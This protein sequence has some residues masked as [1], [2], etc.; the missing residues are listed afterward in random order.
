MCK[1]HHCLIFMA[2]AIYKTKELTVVSSS[3]GFYLNRLQIHVVRLCFEHM[4]IYQIEAHECEVNCLREL[5]F[6]N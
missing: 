1:G 4:T 2:P 3:V 5:V 6:K